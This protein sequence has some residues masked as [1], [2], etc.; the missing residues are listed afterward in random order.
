MSWA[1][2]PPCQIEDC[3]EDGGWLWWGRS[4]SLETVITKPSVLQSLNG[5]WSFC[6]RQHLPERSQ[7]GTAAMTVVIV[8]VT[9]TE[10]PWG[11]WG[12]LVQG[13]IW[14]SVTVSVSLNSHKAFKAPSA[15]SMKAP[16]TIEG[17]SVWTAFVV[18]GKTVRLKFS[19]PRQAY[20]SGINVSHSLAGHG[21]SGENT[22]ATDLTDA[23][24]QPGAV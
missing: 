12:W 18:P 5:I 19:C 24:A 3:R 7:V 14:V 2:A 22:S 16:G 23:L 6:D 10:S 13:L 21:E 20:R 4:E 1:G 15:V 8:P 17:V 9:G 11:I